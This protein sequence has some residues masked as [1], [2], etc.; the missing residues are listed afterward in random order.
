MHQ[1]IN[2]GYEFE[3][4]LFAPGDD[5]T[6]VRTKIDANTEK[7][8]SAMYEF[9]DAIVNNRP[10]PASAE[11]GLK[12]MQILDGLYESAETGEMVRF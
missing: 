4:E 2:D 5:D 11:D 1:N 8:T 10:H 7:D 12:V 9:V 6:L 3:A